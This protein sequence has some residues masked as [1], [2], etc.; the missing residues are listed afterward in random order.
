MCLCELVCTEP[1]LHNKGGTSRLLLATPC[2]IKSD[3]LCVYMDLVHVL[4][5]KSV[6]RN[7]SVPAVK[8]LTQTRLKTFFHCLR[9]VSTKKGSLHAHLQ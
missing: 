9:F 3:L 1:E 4:T 2:G 8:V 6:Q 5:I 7:R